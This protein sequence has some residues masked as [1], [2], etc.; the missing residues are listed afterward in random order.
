MTRF[1]LDKS[2]HSERDTALALMKAKLTNDYHSCILQ[3]VFQ[4]VSPMAPA[5]EQKCWVLIGFQGNNP[6]TDIRDAGL[7]GLLQII[8][9]VKTFPDL[10]KRF[11]LLSLDPIQ[12]FPFAVV[13][14]SFTALTAEA[15]R[16][17]RLT[18]MCNERKSVVKVMNLFYAA[19]FTR[20]MLRWDKEKLTIINR[21]AAATEN[22]TYCKE[23]ARRLV[24]QFLH[25]YSPKS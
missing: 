12:V 23:N 25:S 13:L 20:F 21:D 15:L 14:L 8:Y 7:F 17:G 1:K 16:E 9:F 10:A 24:D 19:A 3:R 4:I 18:T 11:F 22:K 6:E 5:T 2:L